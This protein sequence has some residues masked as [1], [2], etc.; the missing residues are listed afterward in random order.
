MGEKLIFAPLGWWGSGRTLWG[1]KDE[2]DMVGAVKIAC[3]RLKRET[4]G[5]GRGP[6]RKVLLKKMRHWGAK[7]LSLGTL[8]LTWG[9]QFLFIHV[10]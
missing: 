7:G 5:P 2:E 6:Y 1:C 3:R 4:K 10:S 8:P 9:G